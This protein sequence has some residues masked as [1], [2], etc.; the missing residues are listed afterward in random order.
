MTSS[1]AILNFFG[2]VMYDVTPDNRS[3]LVDLVWEKLIK[4]GMICRC[5]CLFQYLLLYVVVS[6][7]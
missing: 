5:D 2:S 1:V 3:K 4:R 7:V 6:G